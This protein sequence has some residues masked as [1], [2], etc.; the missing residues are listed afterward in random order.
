MNGFIF[1]LDLSL[2]IAMMGILDFLMRALSAPTPPR[3]PADI[4]S[5]SSMII[6]DRREIDGSALPSCSACHVSYQCTNTTRTLRTVSP[7]LKKPERLVLSTFDLKA[8][9]RIANRQQISPHIS[10]TLHTSRSF[11]LR[12]SEAFNS[13]MS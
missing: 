5:T 8:V 2:Q 10:T 6:T 7:V 12:V 9:Y 1:G 4:P 13:R 3:S 11:L